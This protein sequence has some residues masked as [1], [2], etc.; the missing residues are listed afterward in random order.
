[1]PRLVRT[2]AILA[3]ATIALASCSSSGG[4]SGA[5]S[6]AGA[7]KVGTLIPVADRKPVPAFSGPLLS[8][9]TYNLSAYKGKAVVVNFW[10]TWCP[11]CVVETPQFQTVYQAYKNRGVSFVG[12]DIKDGT[13]DAP[14]SFVADHHITYPMIYD[15]TGETALR[16]GNIRVQATPFTVLLDREHRVAGVYVSPLTPRDLGPMLDKLSAGT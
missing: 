2:L 11:P 10:G 14:R 8:G 15:E 16:M 7:Q 3:A 6:F 1:M 5:Y 9:G 13:R 4:G 12:I